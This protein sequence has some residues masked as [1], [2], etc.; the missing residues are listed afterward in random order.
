MSSPIPKDNHLL[1]ASC[2]IETL[3]KTLQNWRNTK[4]NSRVLQELGKMESD[5][6]VMDVKQDNLHESGFV[7]ILREDEDDSDEEI[8]PK[9]YGQSVILK[10][11]DLKRVMI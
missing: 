10:T 5:F 3:F 11:I 4:Q 9:L 8:L 7:K 1:I 6:E 2:S